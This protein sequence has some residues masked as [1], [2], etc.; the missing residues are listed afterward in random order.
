[1][2]W[3]NLDLREK[4][5]VAWRLAAIKVMLGCKTYTETLEQ[6]LDIAEPIIFAK[7]KEPK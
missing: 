3:V 2:D 5:K 7:K 4:Q 1:M 6:L